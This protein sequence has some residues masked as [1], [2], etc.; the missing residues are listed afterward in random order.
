MDIYSLMKKDH[1]EVASLF[2]RLQAAEGF[3]E[4]SEQLFAQLR[5]EIEFHTHAEERVFYPALREAEGTQ[6]LVEEAVDDHELIRELL[7]ELA[8]SHMGDE[9][10]NEKLEVLEEHVEEHVE[11]EESDLFDVARQL[12]N[13]EQAVELA[14]R[15]QT[16]KQERMARHAK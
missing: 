12:F 11:E 5:E 3:S 14:Q 1:Q 7:D 4:T 2:R 9:A 15:W 16:A 6:E 13:A 8:T 10:W